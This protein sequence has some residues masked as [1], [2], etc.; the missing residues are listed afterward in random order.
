MS[1]LDRIKASYQAGRADQIRARELARRRAAEQRAQATLAAKKAPPIRAV[2]AAGRIIEGA[3]PAIAG[4]QRV[5]SSFARLSQPR[6]QPKKRSRSVSSA[7]SKQHRLEPRP[8]K[9]MLW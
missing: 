5:A 4:A 3:K 1:Y 2:R 7:G 8:K 6:P 9:S